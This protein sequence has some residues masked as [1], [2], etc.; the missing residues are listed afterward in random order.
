MITEENLQKAKQTIQ[1]FFDKTGFGIEINILPLSDKTIP[2]RINTEDPKVLIGQN[3]QT[4]ADIQHLLKTI[5]SHNI[6]DQFYIDL[7]I[8]NYKEKKMTYIKESAREW[9]DDVALTKK[10]KTLE[11]MPSF[12]RRVIH[13]ELANRSDIKTESIGQGVDRY[14][15]IRPC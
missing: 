14:I 4:L 12:E 15:V 8:N 7:D 1:E 11:P 9:A 10:E 3:G 13:M 6:A 5:V 2:I